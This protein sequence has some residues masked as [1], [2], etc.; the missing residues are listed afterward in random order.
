M[1]FHIKKVAMAAMVAFTFVISPAYAANTIKIGVISILEGAFAAPGADAVRGAKLAFAEANN[2]AGGSNIEF[3]VMSS[4]GSPDSAVNAARKLIEQDK[5]DMIV[6]PVS[7]SEGIALRDLSQAY[8][9]VTFIN[10]SSAAQDAT[11]RDASDNFFRFGGDGAQW[12][13]GVGTYVYEDLNYKKVAV[14]A[15]DYSFPY[16][17]V[18]GFMSEFCAAGGHVPEK[19]WT[20]I[21]A[22]DYSSIVYSIP[23][24]VDAI[25]VALGGADA[26]N[27]LTQY[28]QAGGDKP[29][30]GGSIT[31][32]QT[33]LDSKG[34]FKK[35]LIGAPA[36]TPT[37]SDF[38]GKEWKEFSAS[39]TSTFPDGFSSPSIFAH[40]YYMA[41]KA[42]LLG[43][44][45]VNGDLSNNHKAFRAALT[46]MAFIAPTGGIMRLDE[47][48]N[49]ITDS[50]VTEVF[51][52]EDGS[53]GN[54]VIK[55][56]HNVNQAMGGDVDVFRA[57]GPVSR[58]NPSCP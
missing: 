48:R 39:Y 31:I 40:H 6:G 26:V 28:S 23:D 21:G 18:L 45:Q 7:G 42:A 51:E 9:N 15:E 37:V 16:T 50:F 4:D 3:I 47:N 24:D 22:K 57:N 53:L 56:I 14:V 8:K 34:P 49:G 35:L 41:G 20:P 52:R 29:I 5:V 33:I 36:G 54:R 55:V 43:L 58:D 27:F 10:G 2:Q 17:Q 12:M 44:E 25:F 13:A 1:T 38:D 46:D 11:F 19:F 32:D 30:I